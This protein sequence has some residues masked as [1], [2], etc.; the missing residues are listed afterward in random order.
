MNLTGL[1]LLFL[2]VPNLLAAQDP[3]FTQF[4]SSPLYLNPAFAGSEGCSRITLN[5]RNQ[6]PGLGSPYV[7]YNLSYDQYVHPLRGGLGI[8]TV[9]DNAAQGV[10]NTYSTYGAYAFKW[11]I[12]EKLILSPS[13][14]LGYGR[15][16]VD[17]RKINF[18]GSTYEEIPEYNVVSYFDMGAGLLVNTK[19]IKGGFAVDHINQPI[20][21]FTLSGKPRLPA[22]Y[23]VHLAYDFQKDEDS[24]FTFS[25]GALYQR[26]QS[27]GQLN[28]LASFRYKWLLWSVAFRRSDSFIFGLG[29]QS[30]KLRFGYTFDFTTSKLSNATAGSHEASL[31][32]LFNCKEKKEK[33]IPVGTIS[34]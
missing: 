28:M 9:Y 30:K 32:F 24:K 27:F 33:I 2:L 31:R 34:F 29:V 25:P 7:T 11:R 18:S 13:I 15:R 20:E 5:Y 3:I 14:I 21:R 6:W 17:W 4:H 23:T 26:Q 19:K 12:K 8:Y 16:V 1:I 10:I 22:K